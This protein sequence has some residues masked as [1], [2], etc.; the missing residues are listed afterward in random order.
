LSMVALLPKRSRSAWLWC[1]FH[2][3]NWILFFFSCTCEWIWMSAWSVSVS[4]Y[5]IL[6]IYVYSIGAEVAVLDLVAH[7]SRMWRLRWKTPVL[8][9]QWTREWW[10]VCWLILTFWMWCIRV[11]KFFLLSG[12]SSNTKIT[13]PFKFYLI[14][15]PILLILHHI[16]FFLPICHK[17]MQKSHF[18]F[19]IS[20]FEM[21]FH[22]RSL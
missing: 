13:L 19:K 17:A 5:K 16:H 7:I 2:G 3:L 4:P 20:S 9:G 14:T 8:I 12:I 18:S 1:N 6:L 11:F 21:S 22:W 10:R 15:D